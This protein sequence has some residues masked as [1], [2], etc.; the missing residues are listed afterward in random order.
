VAGGAHGAT[1]ARSTEARV[2]AGGT[3][4]ATTAHSIEARAAARSRSVRRRGPPTARCE[5]IFLLMFVCK[6][7]GIRVHIDLCTDCDMCESNLL[8]ME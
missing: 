6:L 1:T 3:H 4:G 5:W 7:N 2:A 8:L